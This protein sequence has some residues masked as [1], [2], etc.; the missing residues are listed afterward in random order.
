[1]TMS[2]SSRLL[3]KLNETVLTHKYYEAH[4]LLKTLNFRYSASKKYDELETLLS[5]HSVFFLDNKQFES[6]MDVAIMIAN[7]HKAAGNQPTDIRILNALC[8][9]KKMPPSP[10]RGQFLHLILE[11]AG[12]SELSDKLNS[13][14]VQ[15]YIAERGYDEAWRHV[16]RLNDGKVAAIYL[17]QIVQDIGS[18]IKREE[19]GLIT[20]HLVV[21]LLAAKKVAQA[22]Q[23]LITM[24]QTQDVKQLSPLLNG[25]RYLVEAAKTNDP[26]A[27]Q[28]IQKLY[29]LS[30]SRDP[31]LQKLV[32]AAGKSLFNITDERSTN[33]GG[34]MSLF[35]AFMN[36]S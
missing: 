4:Q 7:L 31:S 35:S 34:F 12:S 6:G 5:D 1:M 21:T 9:L 19:L 26:P 16:V 36:N 11:W 24:V 15:M 29:D 28:A 27:F 8:L 17:L 30:F 13:F 18:A 20:A 33:G 22:E 14:A 23:A 10:E 25:I 3:T 32:G 2:G